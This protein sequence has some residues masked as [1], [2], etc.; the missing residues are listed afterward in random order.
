MD[1]ETGFALGGNKTRKL[2]FELAPDRLEG[3]TRIVT[4]G[5]VHSNHCRLT[6][7]AAARLG[8]P[9]TLVLSGEAPSNPTGNAL[10]H[11]LFGADIRRVPERGD[12][13][14]MMAKVA[15]EVGAAGGRA[16]VVPLGASTPLGCLG[17][18]RAAVELHGQLPASGRTHWV[19]VSA[20]SCGTFAGLLLGFALLEREDIRVVGVS[21]DVPE[22]EIR[23]V[24]GELLSGASALLGLEIGAKDVEVLCTEAYIGSGYGIETPE[25]KEAETLFAR[26]EGVILEQAYTAKVGAALIDWSRTGRVASGEG[27]VFLHTGGY[28]T[29]FQ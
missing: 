25:S 7:A 5:G 19:F 26:R 9:C 15:E 3:V 6:V 11:S 4:C 18:A 13:P 14:P 27:I 12:R 1:G 17:Y 10:L 21:P 23:E 2:E 16:L 29:V 20:S 24:T 8:L 22:S 28:P